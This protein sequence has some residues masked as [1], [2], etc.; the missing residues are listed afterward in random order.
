M[1][2]VVNVN[3]PDYDVSFITAKDGLRSFRDNVLNID[4]RSTVT[5]MINQ[6]QVT[7]VPRDNLDNNFDTLYEIVEPMAYCEI[8]I[9]SVKKDPTILMRGFVTNVSKSLDIASG[10]PQRTIT[11]SGENYGKV[12]RMAYIHYAYGLDPLAT[13]GASGTSAPL[14]FG[15]GVD[16]TITGNS[17]SDV[18]TQIFDTLIKRNFLLIQDYLANRNKVTEDL[19]IE[20]TFEFFGVRPSP[21]EVA[22]TK[23]GKFELD[24]DADGVNGKR[25]IGLNLGFLD[26]AA[27]AQ[28]QSV[29]E[30]IQNFIGSPWNEAFTD[31]APENTYLVYRP[32]PWRDRFGSY[33]GASSFTDTV[34]GQAMVATLRP[35]VPNDR[36]DEAS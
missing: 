33:I 35:N 20:E 31:D 17:P 3:Q 5:D 6:W 12:I 10:I 1:A 2:N 36:S 29:M 14:F 34:D 30:F 15:Y 26:P 27:G 8:K 24:V 11:I 22:A 16:V 28:E 25:N 21:G 23:I 7:F 13:V 4:I 19:S 18:M 9:R 32:K